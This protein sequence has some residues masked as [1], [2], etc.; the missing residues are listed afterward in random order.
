MDPLKPLLVLPE[1]E[2]ELPLEVE[3]DPLAPPDPEDALLPLEDV[4]ALPLEPPPPARVVLLWPQW[5][6]QACV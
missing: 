4:E 1:L 5:S 6:A 3:A 2:P